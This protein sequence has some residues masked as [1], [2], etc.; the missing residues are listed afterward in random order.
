M[1]ER[2]MSL[3]INVKLIIR[4]LP[5]DIVNIIISYTYTPQPVEITSDI[6]SYFESKKKIKKMFYD[7]Y[8]HLFQYEKDADIDWLVND[9]ICFMNQNRASYYMY[10]DQLYS[11]FRR[12]YMLKDMEDSVLKKIINKSRKKNVYYQFHIYWGLLTPNERNRF[13]EIQKKIRF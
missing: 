2:I 7:R 8:Q 12:V 4:Q 9:I 13:I 11:I 10:V 6:H 3:P 5:Q 1:T